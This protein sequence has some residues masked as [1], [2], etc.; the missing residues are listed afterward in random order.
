[1]LFNEVIILL[2][3]FQV[4]ISENLNKFDKIKIW[5]YSILVFIKNYKNLI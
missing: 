1:M 2:L 4:N 5:Y 3:F